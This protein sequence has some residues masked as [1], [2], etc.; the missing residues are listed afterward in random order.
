MGKEQRHEH[1]CGATGLL[2]MIVGE[3][4]NA[5][6][7]AV[8]RDVADIA[9]G[10]IDSEAPITVLSRVGERGSDEFV[11]DGRLRIGPRQQRNGLK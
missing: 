10:M 5:H 11:H 9:V 8:E 2:Y 3:R 7:G 4:I 6:R 1:R